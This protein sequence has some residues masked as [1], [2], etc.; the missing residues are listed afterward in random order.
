MPASVV[1]PLASEYFDTAVVDVSNIVPF[2]GGLGVDRFSNVV[3]ERFGFKYLDVQ[4]PGIYR[5]A[6]V[7]ELLVAGFPLSCSGDE[8]IRDPGWVAWGLV[9]VASPREAFRDSL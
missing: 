2:G 6:C 7:F 8:L 3:V 1:E 9:P 5:S 4:A